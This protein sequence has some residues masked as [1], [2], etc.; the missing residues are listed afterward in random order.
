ML[1]YG[2]VIAVHVLVCLVLILVILLQAGRG[3]GLSE[4][5]SGNVGQTLFGTKAN[6]FL[7]KATTACAVLFLVT[8]LILGIMTSRRGKSLVQTKGW[9]PEQAQGI[10]L[11]QPVEQEK[12]KAVLD[13]AEES[14]PKAEPE[15]PESQ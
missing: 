15:T 3:G 1:L 8:C 11:A 12:E 9:M 13:E 6:V 5:F 14:L 10:P 7:T 2:L 4:A